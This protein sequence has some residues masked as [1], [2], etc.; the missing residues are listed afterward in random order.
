MFGRKGRSGASGT[1]RSR[2]GSPFPLQYHEAAAGDRPD[3]IRTDTTRTTMPDDL[4]RLDFDV[5]ELCREDVF[6]DQRVG[7]IRR[8]VPVRPDGSEDPSRNV[9]FY[10]ETSLLTPAGT[11]PVSF[12]LEARSLEEAASLFAEAAR[13]ALE[14]TVRQ[15]RELRQQA[16]SSIVVPDASTTASLRGGGK[17]QIP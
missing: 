16:A 2:L 13:A 14:D 3:D 6:T 10:G 1:H 4:T 15:L 9:Q 11:L 17:I 5:Q 8:L 7:T 12:R